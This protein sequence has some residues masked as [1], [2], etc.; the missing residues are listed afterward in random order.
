LASQRPLLYYST[1][2]QHV[3]FEQNYANGHLGSIIS[4]R[5]EKNGLSIVNKTA[6]CGR[7]K[8]MLSSLGVGEMK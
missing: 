6:G 1:F 2:G 3:I 4:I 5:H 8:E 7:S